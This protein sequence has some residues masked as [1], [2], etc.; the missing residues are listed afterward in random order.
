VNDFVHLVHHKPVENIVTIKPP[1]VYSAY[2]E[3]TY[4]SAGGRI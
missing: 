4:F 3:V 1:C 2:N